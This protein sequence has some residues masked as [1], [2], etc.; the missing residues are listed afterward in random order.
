MESKRY[1]EDIDFKK[2]WLVLRRHWLPATSVFLLTVALVA[3]ISFLKKPKYQAEG[4][5]LLKKKNTT[6]ALITGASEKIGQLEPLNMMNSPL[7]TEVEVI[8][9]IPLLQ[10]TIAILKLKDN[11][12]TPLEPEDLLKKLKIKGIKGTDVLQITL[13]SKDPKEAANIVNT[14][15]NIYLQNNVLTNRAEAVAARKF[16]TE[17]LPKSEE[18][19]RQAEAALREFKEKNNVV[20]LEEEEKSAVDTLADL[21][22]KIDETQTTLEGVT[23]RSLALQS[24][25]GLNPQQAIALN[26]LRQA[27]GVQDLL[28][29]VQKLESQLSADQARFQPENPTIINSKFK[30]DAKKELLQ[31]R[32][33]QVVGRQQQVPSQNLQISDL[34]QKLIG[35]QVYA[36][37]QRT[38]LANQVAFLHRAQIAYKQ[39]V[40]V[41]PRLQQIQRDLQRKVEAAQSSYQTLLKSLQEIRIA[42]NQNVG[43][44]SVIAYAQVPERPVSAR[45]MKVIAVGIV[46]GSM[47]YVVTAFLVDLM[48]P[49]IKTVKD[50]REL[51]RYT[52]LGMIPDTKKKALFRKRKPEEF[53]PQLPVRD[54]PHAVSSEAY[55]MLQANLE[56]LSPDKELKAIVVTSSVSKEG[57]STV[58]ANLAI[59]MAQLDRRVLLVDAD[60][61]HPMQHHIWNLANAVGLSDVIVNQAGFSIAVREV[62][63]N[64]DVLPSGVIPPNPLTLLDSK[65][66]ASLIKE[67]SKK[68]DFVIF[69][70]PPVVLAADALS[71]SKMTDGVLL[72][73]RPGVLDRVSAAAAKEFLAQSGQEI[74]GL[75]VNGVRVENEPDSYFHHAKTYY[76]EELTTR[77]ALLSK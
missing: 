11:K 34:Q 26:S 71:L 61:R 7:D 48:D 68:Y 37:V 35:D 16:I 15:I 69:D 59:A 55:R 58:S 28:E 38:D 70:T 30:L 29:E 65:R 46:V 19:V 45:K 13:D 5:L 9:S 50:L 56:F 1:V 43:N 3:G 8:R 32:I 17:Q 10:K 21:D 75:V 57:K 44:A 23:A 53:V 47:L 64:L 60:L 4:R 24:K 72:V 62:M 39:R 20:A 14:L 67:F 6:S 18:T 63:D 54:V 36:E 2:Y 76:A 66:M 73:S 74:L 49:S 33:A 40:N 42:E 51:F 22:K 31:K 77:N 27:P 25:T 41:L 52:W 12:G